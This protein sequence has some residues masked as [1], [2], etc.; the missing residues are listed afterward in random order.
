MFC[1]YY[2]E[3]LEYLK[4]DAKWNTRWEPAIKESNIGHPQKCKEYPKSSSN[5]IHHAYHLAQFESKTGI[6]I[7]ELDSVFEFGGG[8]G[9]MCRLFANLGFKGKYIIYDFPEFSA[10]QNYY[11]KSLGIINNNKTQNG[12]QVELISNIDQIT[13]TINNFSK[14]KNLFLATW[15]ISETPIDFRSMFFPLLQNKFDYYLF[16]YQQQFNEVDNIKYFSNIQS[17]IPTNLKW[18]DWK[19]NHLPGNN[20]YLI[21]Y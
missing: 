19:I 13:S 17:E 5:L 6:E 7:N 11:L 16:C 14:Q 10:L 3:E 4:S 15:S 12:I 21:G 2:P 8:Y 9:S 18:A 20:H 1:D